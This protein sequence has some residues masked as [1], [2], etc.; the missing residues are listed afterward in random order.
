MHLGWWK[1]MW[2]HCVQSHGKKDS[3]KQKTTKYHTHDAAIECHGRTDGTVLVFGK[4]FHQRISYESK[5]FG[6]TVR[7][8]PASEQCLI[9]PFHRYVGSSLARKWKFAQDLPQNPIDQTSSC[10]VETITGIILKVLKQSFD[11]QSSSLVPHGLRQETKIV[12]AMEQPLQPSKQVEVMA[13]PWYRD[14]SWKSCNDNPVFSCV[15]H[16]F[17]CNVQSSS[18][19]SS[20][21]V[22]IYWLLAV[23]MYNHIIAIFEKHDRPLAC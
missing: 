6:E 3:W 18:T 12:D 13:A 2:T 22:P 7:L 14:S 21:Q 15:E 11:F 10:L 23:G 5:R 9:K 20:L 19:R 8:S 1:T 4:A 16:V 17:L